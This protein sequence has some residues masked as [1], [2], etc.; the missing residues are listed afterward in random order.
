MVKIAVQYR[1]CQSTAY[2]DRLQR[3]PLVPKYSMTC[4][5]DLF[6]D[7]SS[8]IKHGDPTRI[9]RSSF[10]TMCYCQPYLY[11]SL[12]NSVGLCPLP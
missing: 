2:G 4:R 6:G 12:I 9:L 8:H 1:R 5:W 11:P 3:R 10:P 7:S